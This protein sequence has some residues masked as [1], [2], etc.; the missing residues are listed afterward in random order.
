MS[1]RSEDIKRF[2][3]KYKI[4]KKT[5]CWLWRGYLDK[6]GY[7]NFWEKGRLVRAHRFSYAAF[8]GPVGKMLVCHSCDNAS[9]VNPEHLFLGTQQNN[10]DDCKT[11]GRH[12]FGFKHYR[13]KLS[14]KDIEVIISLWKKGYTTGYISKKVSICKSAIGS[15][16]NSRSRPDLRDRMLNI[17]FE[18]PGEL[19]HK[20]RWFWKRSE[21]GWVPFRRRVENMGKGNKRIEK[22]CV[23]CSLSFFAKNTRGEYCSGKCSGKG[24]RRKHAECQ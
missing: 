4:D 10:I 5:D 21:K 19:D 7:G 17:V 11:K 24:F 22:T 6:D 23:V 16:L 9:C 12:P 18:Y 14:E 8:I 20:N 15:V 1:L 3:S 13:S 2:H